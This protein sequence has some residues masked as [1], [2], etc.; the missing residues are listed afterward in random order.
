MISSVD[1]TA[2]DVAQLAHVGR[3]PIWTIG[4]E[5]AGYELLFRSG[6]DTHAAQTGSYATGQVVV[7][8][9]TEFG[10]RELVGD[11]LC[12][13]NMTRGF[14]LGELPL[15][16]EPG[17]VVLEVL[18]T[19]DLDEELVAGVV[20]LAAKGYEIALDD[21][22][23]GSGHEQLLEVASYVKLD[24]RGADPA[25]LRRVAQACRPYPR[26]RLVAEK[27]ETD[28][29]LALARE[30]GCELVQGYL[31]GRPQTMS[32]QA[33]MPSRVGRVQLMAALLR[34]DIKVNEVVTMVTRDPALSFRLLR[35]SNSLPRG[36]SRPVSSVREAVVLMG[37]AQVRQW[38]S[39]M[40]LSDQFEADEGQVTMT[41]AHARMCQLV[42]ELLGQCPD[43]GFTVGLLDR[44][45]DLLSVPTDELVARLPLAEPVIGALVDGTG[46][47]GR[48]LRLTH[49]YED[50]DLA[51][52]GRAGAE[53]AD[54][55]RA[56]LAAAKWSMQATGGLFDRRPP[57]GGLTD[58]SVG[59]RLEN[60]RDR[61]A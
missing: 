51:L 56:F 60:D 14:L 21:L 49:A 18:E 43:T 40:A 52:V 44:V 34:P 28:D 4:G 26:V 42:A 58:G 29:D 57:A 6:E 13:I 39:L 1:P 53:P 50:G 55:S 9:F 12:F 38:V 41:L 16:F 23:W 25:A 11:R 19:V 36:L 48:A 22:L 59:D 30:L 8:A 27:V 31:L 24:L 45:A 61:V 20:A 35:A 5:L 54:L 2:T 7:S 46:E 47:L 17:Q 3:Q 15:P 33:L 32:V 37:I 10:V